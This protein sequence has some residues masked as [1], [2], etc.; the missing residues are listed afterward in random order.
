MPPPQMPPEIQASIQ[1][2]KLETD[3]KAAL[4]QA[5]I[6]LKNAEA[7]AKQ[8]LELAQLQLD[9]MQQAFNQALPLHKL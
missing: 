2:A 6:G 7:Q 4:D 1:I 3:R 9:K 8:Q 5:T